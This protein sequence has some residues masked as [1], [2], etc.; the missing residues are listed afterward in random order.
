M[1]DILQSNDLRGLRR[2]LIEAAKLNDVDPRAM[3]SSGSPIIQ[4]S[5]SRLH[6]RLQMAQ[7]GSSDV[8]TIRSFSAAD[9]RVRRCTEV[10][11]STRAFVMWLSPGLVTSLCIPDSHS[12]SGLYRKH[13]Q[14]ACEL[15]LAEV[16]VGEF[17]KQVGLA[18]FYDGKLDLAAMYH[19]R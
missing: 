17:S 11:T 5:G 1:R 13:T 19:D 18:L 4:P 12:Q 10:I 6:E 16:D 9:Q 2:G 14:W 3:S 15:L 7:S 8:A